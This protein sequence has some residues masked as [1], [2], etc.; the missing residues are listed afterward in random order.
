MQY[1]F[2]GDNKKKLYDKFHDFKCFSQNIYRQQSFVGTSFGTFS[3]FSYFIKLTFLDDLLV[4]ICSRAN[5]S[6]PACQCDTYLST[7]T[8]FPLLNNCQSELPYSVIAAGLK[9]SS[10]D[11]SN[12]FI[13]FPLPVLLSIAYMYIRKLSWRRPEYFY[14]CIFLSQE[15]NGSH[16]RPKGAKDE[17][18]KPEGP[19]ARLLVW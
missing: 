7:W 1:F 2:F 14:I 15:K 18:K 6:L 13:M 16:G 8:R 4:H 11:K 10:W 19:P 17:V 5:S 3:D 9:F 12:L